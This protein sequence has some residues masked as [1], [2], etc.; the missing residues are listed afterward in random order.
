MVHF[1]LRESGY[2]GA[3]YSAQSHTSLFNPLRN[4]LAA[5]IKLEQRMPTL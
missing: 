1:G 5:N 2:L 3:T 4:C